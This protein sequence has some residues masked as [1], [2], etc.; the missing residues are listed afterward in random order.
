MPLETYAQT[1]PYA[2]AIRELT[3]LRQMPPWFADSCCGRFSNNSSLSN[4]EIATLGEWAN[5]HAPAGSRS[6]APPPPHWQAGWNIGR[7]DIVLAMPRAKRIPAADDVPYQYIIIPTGFKE[8]R[9]VRMSEI[10]PSN[11]AVVHHAVA[12]IRPPSSKWLRGAP[13]GV[14]FSEE[15]RR[16]AR[17]TDSDILLVYAPGSLPDRWPDGFAELVPAGSGTA[18][19]GGAPS[20]VAPTWPV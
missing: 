3:K 19:N 18:L 16:D 9:W 20:P 4:R 2:A 5:A 1:R 11:R 12:Y 6:S 14:P 17:W 13:V 10:R 15:L 8:D 7:P